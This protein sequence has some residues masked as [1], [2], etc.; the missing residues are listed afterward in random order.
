MQRTMSGL[1]LGKKSIGFVPTMGSLHQGHVSLMKRA[2]KEN[3]VAAIS[4]FV[5]P[6]QFGPNEDYRAYP[7]NF[8]SD[9]DACR[10]CRMDYVFYPKSQDMYAPDHL[11]RVEVAQLSDLFCGK[12]RK[13]HFQGVALIVLKL[14]H[15]VMPTSAY[16]GL[17]DYQQYLIIK[18]MVKDLDM[19]IRIVGMPVV[20]EKIGLAL[21][22][23]NAYLS[24]AEKEEAALLSMAL[25][26]AKGLVQTGETDS[27]R[28][29]KSIYRIL[30]S[31]RIIKPRDIEYIG[32]ADP[33]TL[34]EKK[35]VRRPC[36]VALAVRIGS[37]RLIDNILI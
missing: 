19:N 29:R 28:V 30:L 34:E 9:M 33:E 5:N 12:T 8:A 3:R 25:F 17:K 37:T 23:R 6:A 14:F 2:R 16:F 35:T 31:G 36:L 22:S 7:R 20:R 32:I 18:K 15:I 10:F 13:G 24:P 1:K 27:A 21:S 26:Y 4:I 11:T